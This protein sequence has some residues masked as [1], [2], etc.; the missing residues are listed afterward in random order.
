MRLGSLPRRS[1]WASW[2][3]T[4][5]PS[6]AGWRY[7]LNDRAAIHTAYPHLTI[8]QKFDL[9]GR[10]AIVTG[11]AG[12][13]GAEF[14]RTLAE[15]GA[16]VVVVDVNAPASQVTADTLTKSG[17]KALAAPSDITRPESV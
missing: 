1:R 16:A 15:A 10:V 6:T 9:T 4:Y 5:W 7:R 17:Y 12:L 8:Q 13:L 2:S 14:C 11:G 3:G